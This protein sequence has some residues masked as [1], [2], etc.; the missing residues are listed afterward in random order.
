MSLILTKWLYYRERGRDKID[1]FIANRPCV[2]LSTVMRNE[3]RLDDNGIDVV[4]I[5]P[6]AMM[7][8]GVKRH[9]PLTH[10]FK[11]ERE[12]TNWL[13]ILSE[14]INRTETIIFIRNI[15]DVIDQYPVHREN[16]DDTIAA[17]RRRKAIIE[18]FI[19]S[20][21][22]KKIVLMMNVGRVFENGRYIEGDHESSIIERWNTIKFDKIIETWE[23]DWWLHG[24][25]LW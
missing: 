16:V 12:Y 10:E 5:H 25:T 24:A 18:N 19:T 11:T 6:I 7:G 4:D 13:S 21:P 20:F 23:T 22:N 2:V 1:L 8:T 15:G 9:V 14:V 3:R 17:I